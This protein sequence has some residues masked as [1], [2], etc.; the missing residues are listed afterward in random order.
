ML[1]RCGPQDAYKVLFDYVTNQADFTESAIREILKQFEVATPYYTLIARANGLDDPFTDQVVEAYW[2][3]NDLLDK[4]RSE[5]V[6]WV[7]EQDVKREGWNPEQIALMFRA[8]TLEKARAH[9]S[10]S[11]LY[12][13]TRPGIELEPLVAKSIQK[14]L[15]DCRVCSGIVIERGEQLTVMYQPLLFDYKRIVRIGEPEKKMVDWGM[16]N[17]NDSAVDT[18]SIIAFHH[19]WAIEC[20]NIAQAQNLD[21]YT[22]LT[23]AAVNP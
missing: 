5:A 8:I 16:L 10:L 14:S 1:A 13:F 17:P 21:K 4:V 20:L 12:F 9:H 15:D 6:G 22:R 18:G 23:L 2:L 11:V 7:I 19:A 3:G